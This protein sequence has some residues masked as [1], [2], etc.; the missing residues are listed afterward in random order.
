MTIEQLQK[1][2]SRFKSKNYVTILRIAFE[3][4][5]KLIIANKWIH[6]KTTKQIRKI[7]DLDRRRC[8]TKDFKNH[9]HQEYYEQITNKKKIRKIIRLS[10]DDLRI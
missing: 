6:F 4:V 1:N 3:F 8:R 9:D 7:H 10:N 5:I 2:H